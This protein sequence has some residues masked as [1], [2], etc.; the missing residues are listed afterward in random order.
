VTGY[1]KE[2]RFKPGPRVLFVAFTVDISL[3]EDDESFEGALEPTHVG[4][5]FNLTIY[6]KLTPS[7]VVDVDSRG[8]HLPYICCGK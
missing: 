5:S 4:Y 1:Q 6:H 8:Y 7:P 3:L 2:L